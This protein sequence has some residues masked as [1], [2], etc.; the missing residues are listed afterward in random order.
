MANESQTQVWVNKARRGDALALSKLLAT[1][2]PALRDRL[3]ARMDP[4]LGARLDPE[5]ILQQV[6]LEVFQHVERFEQRDPNSFFNWVLTILDH[7]LIDARRALHRR[8]RDI[9]R[10]VKPRGP[11]ATQSYWSLL[12]QLF[13]DS[14]TPS[15]VVRH[16]EAVGA[17]LA[18]L[19]RL[20]DS[21]RQVIQLRFLE[22]RSVTDVAA[23]L[24]KTDAAVVALTKRAL[25][26]L[27]KSMDRLGEFTR[28]T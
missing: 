8:M 4:P 10:E 15:R 5:D 13:A 21:H 2:H 28:G 22:G 11:N 14:P 26:A 23:R 6:Y 7:K 1:F 3:A 24:D 17:L 27:R 9:D 19:S 12:D 16:D 18:C 20:S 25:D